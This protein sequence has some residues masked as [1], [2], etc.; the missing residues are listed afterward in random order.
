[1]RFLLVLFS[2]LA[3]VTLAGLIAGL[4]KPGLMFWGPLK[5]RRQALLIYGVASLALLTFAFLAGRASGL[6]FEKRSVTTRTTILNKT[7]SGGIPTIEKDKSDVLGP[8][9]TSSPAGATVIPAGARPGQLLPSEVPGYQI[10]ARETIS[11][12]SSG[13]SK[14]DEVSFVVLEPA[15]ASAS[16]GTEKFA[17][18]AIHRFAGPAVISSPSTGSRSIADYPESIRS[19]IPQEN[20]PEGIRYSYSSSEAAWISGSYLFEIDVIPYPGK[21]LDDGA[22]NQLSS[23]VENAITQLQSGKTPAA[24]LVQEINPRAELTRQHNLCRR[25]ERLLNFI[26][27]RLLP[28]SK[29]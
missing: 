14:A 2:L 4:A 3:G 19:R 27:G 28:P 26:K 20:T 17:Y 13:F 16:F 23:M 12:P 8:K 18:I 10:V 11:A 7:P 9:T 24:G 5:T 15:P 25:T 1:M 22:V 29:C 21:K 6:S